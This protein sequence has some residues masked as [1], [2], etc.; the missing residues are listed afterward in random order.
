[1]PSLVLP[2]QQVASKVSQEGEGSLSPNVEHA[3]AS[4]SSA[5][6]IASKVL[7]II[8][9]YRLPRTK[10]DAGKSDGRTSKFLPVIYNHVRAG[11]IIPMCL[12]AFPFKSPNR[13]AKVLGK[14]PDRA[15]ELALAHL[16]GLCQA[17]GDIYPPG[18]RL[19]IISD[20]LVYNGESF[21]TYKIAQIQWLM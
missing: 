13:L 14:L 16:D 8:D 3:S 2:D 20:G 7:D 19:T 1:M 12:P 11:Q 4:D 6:G 9:R 21:V 17:I 10:P 15:E 5:H 18:A